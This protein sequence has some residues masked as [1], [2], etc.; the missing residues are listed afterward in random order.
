M[1]RAQR[2]FQA[3]RL[4]GRLTGETRLVPRWPRRHGGLLS[5]LVMT[6]PGLRG[7]MMVREHAL[8]APMI[9]R[10]GVAVPHAPCPLASGAGMSHRQ[11]HDLLLDVPGQEDFRR[12]LPSWV[13]QPALIA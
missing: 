3:L 11:P 13:G 5:P 12:R 2:L 10:R 4:G 8:K 1:C 7:A 6:P 9:D